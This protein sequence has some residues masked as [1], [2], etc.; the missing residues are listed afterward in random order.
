VAEGGSF[1]PLFFYICFILLQPKKTK[2]MLTTVK[3]TIKEFKNTN[4]QKFA[5]WTFY[6]KLYKQA[7]EMMKVNAKYLKLNKWKKAYTKFSLSCQCLFKPLKQFYYYISL[8]K[9][10]VTAEY[11]NDVLIRIQ[12][13]NCT[14]KTKYY[15]FNILV[16]TLEMDMTYEEMKKIV[17]EK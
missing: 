6:F 4:T 3:T 11:R 16:F 12:G 17:E 13:V 10:T 7:R 8:S 15:L 1:A 14:K 2:A 9:G 5:G